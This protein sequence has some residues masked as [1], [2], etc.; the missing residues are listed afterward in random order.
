MNND[1][2]RGAG[3]VNE[4]YGKPIRDKKTLPRGQSP[5][6]IKRET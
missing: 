6:K 1:T 4:Y 3:C 5:E 2:R